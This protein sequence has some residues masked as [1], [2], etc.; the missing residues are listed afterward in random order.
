MAFIILISIATVPDSF[1][2][3]VTLKGMAG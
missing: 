1:H 3:G 2:L